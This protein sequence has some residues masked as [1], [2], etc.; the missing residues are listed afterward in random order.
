MI[1]HQ[2]TPGPWITWNDD[3]TEPW[4]EDV[5]TEGDRVLI[6]SVRVAPP[7]GET[8]GNAALIAAA[9]ELLQVA[10]SLIETQGG[11]C[12]FDVLNPCTLSKV[13]GKHW[14]SEQDNPVEACCV[15]QAKLA[16]AKALN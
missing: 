10:I 7:I 16:I 3:L 2:F 13:P 1:R 12:L 9:P 11:K 8:S 6:A 4:R 14:G 5:V 15:C